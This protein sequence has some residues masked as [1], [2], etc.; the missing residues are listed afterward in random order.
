[1]TGR[2]PAN[3][4]TGTLPEMDAASAARSIAPGAT[5]VV[6]G[7]GSVGYPKA[8][9]SELAANWG[10]EPGLT[11]ISGGSLGPEIDTE[12][13]QSGALAYR[14]PYQARPAS[15][16]AI[17]EGT[18]NFEDRHV[19]AIGEEVI[20]GR[21]GSVDVAI[22]EAV[23]VGPDWLV[24]STALGPTPSYVA[25]AD[26]LIIELNRAQPLALGELH[27]V[28]HQPLPPERDPIPLVE[29]G[30][31]IGEPW[32]T[33]DPDQLVAV[34]DTATP[35]T[36]YSFREPTPAD[37]AIAT[38]M[39]ELL[40]TELEAD[41]A[42][43]DRVALQFGVG[44]LGN[45]LMG[46]LESVPFG[47]R[48]VVYYGEVIQDGLL[49]LVD[50]GRL[51]IASAASLALSA[52]GQTRLF[53]D[54]ERYAASIVLRPSAISNSPALI[55]QLGVI[56]VNS[57]LEVD[58]YGHVNSTH[59]AGSHIV[60]GV[61]G[62][63]DFLRNAPL[64]IVTLGATAADGDISRIVPM[65]P[66]VDHTEHDVDVVITDEGV[67]DLRGLA[68]AARAEALIANCAAPAYRAPLVRYCENAAGTGHEPHDRSL[69]LDWED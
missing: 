48:E 51:D 40:A 55:R 63:G 18:L 67:A 27:D 6:S 69:A 68:P 32:I 25:A 57:A 42:F 33:F 62:S 37:E 45:A 54:I 2:A 59:L 31:R 44:S 5:V 15:R 11:L 26:R 14:A 41:P 13:V 23:A 53:D 50:S 20:R 61:G 16:T 36:P 28:Y 7:F 64:S 12:M 58:L 29:P 1:M 46:A 60:N 9:P 21:Y 19:S 8:V 38:H 3:R 17:N 35:D 66:H 52:D 22:V 43:D 34:V 24:P 4:R 49:D 47:S 30:D 39:A 65:V 10:E 56:A